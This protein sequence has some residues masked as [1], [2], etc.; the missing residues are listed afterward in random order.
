MTSELTPGSKPADEPLPEPTRPADSSPMHNPH[1]PFDIATIAPKRLRSA[2]SL[3][4]A[5]NWFVWLLELAAIA[6]PVLVLLCADSIPKDHVTW[7]KVAVSVDRGDF[8]VPVL[9]LCV[10]TVRRWWHEARHRLIF[11]IVRWVATI[12]CS[13]AAIVCLIAMTTA[14]NVKV[15]A[16]T[17]RSITIIT[18]WWMAAAIAFGTAGV[19]SSNREVDD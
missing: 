4:R 9:I 18:E 7:A 6:V 14:A 17:G 2:S 15:T 13:A 3:R 16:E 11:K 5:D 10:D 1:S 19:I 12:G 8:L